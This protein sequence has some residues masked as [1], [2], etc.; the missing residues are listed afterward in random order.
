[1]LSATRMRTAQEVCA[2]YAEF[3]CLHRLYAFCD[4]C[5][6]F[7]ADMREARF[8]AFTGFM[9]SA[10]N[11]FWLVT[12]RVA[13]IPVK[14]QCLHRLYAFCDLLQLVGSRTGNEEFQCLH[15]LY[16]FCDDGI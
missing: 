9:L 4:A 3:Q 12:G 8:N 7:E 2:L 1:M 14:F 15:R 11:V 10:T 13:E 16:A 5:D 6:H